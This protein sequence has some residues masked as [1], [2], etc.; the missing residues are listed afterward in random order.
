MLQWRAVMPSNPA[1]LS[2]LRLCR[3]TE[4]CQASMEGHKIFCLMLSPGAKPPASEQGWAGGTGWTQRQR[5][6]VGSCWAWSP[7]EASS[8]SGSR[9]DLFPLKRAPRRLFK[10]LP[11]PFIVETGCRCDVIPVG[12]LETGLE[13]KTRPVASGSFWVNQ[14]AVLFVSTTQFTSPH[15]LCYWVIDNGTA[16]APCISD[17]EQRVS[18][19]ATCFWELYIFCFPSYP[20]PRRASIAFPDTQRGLWTQ[21]DEEPLI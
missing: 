10:A 2:L 17:L 7:T 6:G 3:E 4:A 16:S 14:A 12:C 20:Y 19:G 8:K 13:S 9:L 21:K 1:E 18:W 15:R 5:G 11:G